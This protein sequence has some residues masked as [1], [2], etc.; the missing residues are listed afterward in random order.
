MFNTLT[1]NPGIAGTSGMICATALNRQQWIG[2]KGAPSTTVFNISAPV[3]LFSIKSGVGLLVESDNIGFDKDINL[4]ASYSYLMDLGT[5]KLGIG[6]SLGMLNK[7]LTPTWQIPSGDA[8]TPVSGDPLIPESKES[9]VAFDAGL[10][11]YYK[12]EKYYASLSVTHIN[13]P[14]I[15]FSK[16]E[17]FISRHYY[18]TGGYNLQLPDPALELLPSFFAFSDGKVVQ[19]AVTSLIRYNKKVWGGV[20]YRAGDALIGI[21]GLELFNGIRLGYSYDFTISDI[22]KNSTGTH[23]FMINYCFDLNLGKSPMKYKSI[24]FL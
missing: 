5:G 4:S 7:T 20:S 11:L 19:V 22:R 10:G 14:K 8:H 17:P 16:G 24:R 6:L 12:A 15:K 13:Q 1:Y 9:V 23:E 2:F 3:S 18:L 21:I